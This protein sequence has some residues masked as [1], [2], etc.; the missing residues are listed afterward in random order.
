LIGMETQQYRE[1]LN[2]DRIKKLKAMKSAR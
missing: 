1:F 2:D